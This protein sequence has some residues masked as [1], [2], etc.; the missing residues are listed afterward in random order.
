MDKFLIDLAAALLNVDTVRFRMQGIN[1]QN[2]VYEQNAENNFTSYLLA[3]YRNTMNAQPG[4]YGGLTIDF[5]IMKMRVGFRPDFVLHESNTSRR[6]QIFIG[7]VKTALNANI[8]GDL[9]NLLTAITGDLRFK[10]AVMVVINKSYNSTATQIVSF[11]ENNNLLD[12]PDIA[13]RI[14]LFH[15]RLN[16]TSQLPEYKFEN[17][18]TVYYNN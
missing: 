7:E 10:N 14:W 11:I 8:Q 6:K 13:N 4:Y 5:D 16:A 18:L 3:E 2:R 15:A 17:L 1:R 9:G 12:T